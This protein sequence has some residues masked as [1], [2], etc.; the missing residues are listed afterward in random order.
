MRCLRSN[1]KSGSDSDVAD[2]V[3]YG[4]RVKFYP[5][6]AAANPPPTVF[7]DAI[8][9]VFDSTIPYDLRFFQSL[10]RMIQIEP[11]LDRDRVMIDVLK[12]I[13]IEKGKP[14]SPD[15]ARRALLESAVRDAHDWLE[16][17]YESVFIPP[18]DTSAK[19][20]LPASK[21]LVEGL[22][23]QFGNPNSY[24]T[25]ARG[26]AYSYAYFSAKHLGAGQ[27]Y[28]MTIKDRDGQRAEWRPN[29]S[30]HRAGQ[31]ACKTILVGDNL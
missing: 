24:P 5:L 19:W 4:K 3:A 30:A 11:W 13:G 25:N 28:L 8:D 2:A 21:E 16:A 26:L 20:A 29:L 17:A 9:A 31:C 6:S 1:L 23:T 12:S 22:T 15:A 10:D 14:F 7:L 18:F 27:F